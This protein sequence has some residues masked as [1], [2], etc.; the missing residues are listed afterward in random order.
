MFDVP[1]LGR[2]YEDMHCPNCGLGERVSPPL[3][4]GSS[5]YHNCPRMHGLSAPLI[6][7]TMDAK[8][9]AV[10]REDYLR[11][12]VQTTGDDGKAYM[13]VK[14]TYADGRNDM[15]VNAPLARGNA[16]NG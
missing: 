11:S 3:P 7:V 10:E 8:V 12:E 16:D 15:A 14:T 9:E 13:A 5:R 2:Q 6:P 1:M 4:P